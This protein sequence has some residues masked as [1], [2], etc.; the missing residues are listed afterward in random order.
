MAY[1]NLGRNRKKTFLVILSLS[2][3]IVL[4]AVTFLFANG[5]SMEK[6]LKN[7]ICADFIVGNTDYFRFRLSE[8][9]ALSRE[10]VHEIKKNTKAEKAEKPGLFREIR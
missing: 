7:Q 6:Y 5:F 9:S 1:A 4:L 8:D 3:A 10:T 2:L